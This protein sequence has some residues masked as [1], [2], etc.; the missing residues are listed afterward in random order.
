MLR[1]MQR[2]LEWDEVEKPSLTM[3]FAGKMEDWYEEYVLNFNYEDSF[4]C[5]VLTLVF[6]I[7][8]P[9]K[10]TNMSYVNFCHIHIY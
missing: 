5:F 1:W 8:S 7:Q 6:D 2:S 9:A 4:S 10:R 3:F